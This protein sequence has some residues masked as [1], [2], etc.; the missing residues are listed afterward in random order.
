[1][2]RGTAAGAGRPARARTTARGAC[3]SEPV[4]AIEPARGGLRGRRT[5]VLRGLGGAAGGWRVDRGRG[6]LLERQRGAALPA[7]A[8]R[9]GRGSALG[10][11][12]TGAGP[13]GA[14]VAGGGGTR[15]A[16]ARRGTHGDVRAGDPV[17]AGARGAVGS[18][19]ALARSR[20]VQSRRGGRAR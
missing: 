1:A 17:R 5:A 13:R 4:L 11:R 12:Q 19:G 10:E 18:A 3:R 7:G 6:P 9:G 8:A 20:A 15:R 2:T 16:R 14:V